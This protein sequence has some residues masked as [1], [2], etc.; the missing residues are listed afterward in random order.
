MS[1]GVTVTLDLKNAAPSEYP[2][3][4]EQLRLMGLARYV[5]GNVTTQILLPTTTCYGIFTGTSATSV[6]DFLHK[7]ITDLFRTRGL[8]FE[9]FIAVGGADTTWMHDTNKRT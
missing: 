2:Y 6:R 9:V 5:T 1:Y 3:I 7:R 8:I 4:Y